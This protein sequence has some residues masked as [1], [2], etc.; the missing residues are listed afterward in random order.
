MFNHN[1]R[2]SVEFWNLKA[3]KL[4]T[5]DLAAYKERRKNEGVKPA[6]IKHELENLSAAL[7]RANDERTPPLLK[8]GRSSR[9]AW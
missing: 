9:G 1:M 8:D 2:T 5:A 3:A 4:T 7:Y 6:T